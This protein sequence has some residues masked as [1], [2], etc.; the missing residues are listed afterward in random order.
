MKVMDKIKDKMK[1][2]EICIRHFG[3]NVIKKNSNL[4]IAFVSLILIL[5][6]M[7]LFIEYPKSFVVNISFLAINTLL[8]IY[9]IETEKTKENV[10]MEKVILMSSIVFCCI[11]CFM[12]YINKLTLPFI[13]LSLLI[14]YLIN[15]LKVISKF[16][17]IHKNFFIIT[18]ISATVLGSISVKNWQILA[19]I[20]LSTKTYLSYISILYENKKKTD[21]NIEKNKGN[22][23]LKLKK[24]EAELDIIDFL[25]YISISVSDYLYKL[26]VVNCIYK[27]LFD[28][29]YELEFNYIIEILFNVKYKLELYFT[30]GFLTIVIFTILYIVI[31]LVKK[32][33]NKKYPKINENL[34]DKIFED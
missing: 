14:V 17:N 10:N 19:L 4:V 20:F 34:A 24:I 32:Y 16:L 13:I 6:W 33:I 15:L 12:E 1:K 18:L 25:T 2:I 26:N 23:K 31:V 22:Y 11:C 5:V 28:E 27:F 9:L 29:K 7:F 21:S 30:K 3:S 8:I